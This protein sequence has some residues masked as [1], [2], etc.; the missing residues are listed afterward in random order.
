MKILRLPNRVP[1]P[2]SPSPS[3]DRISRWL[4]R[5]SLGLLALFIAGSASF[6]V[7]PAAPEIAI[8]QPAGITLGNSIL[9][10]GDN[11][12]GQT[13]VPAGLTDVQA[14]AAGLWHTV[15]LK[16]DGTVI[17]WGYN[18]KSSGP[19]AV[20]AGMGDVWAIA[21]GRYHTVALKNDGTVIS[22]GNNSNGQTTLPAG[23]PGA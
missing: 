21:A 22:W 5:S 11:A 23:L 3:T 4:K 15:A 16:N 14:I 18:F 1:P 20:P 9:A 7:A 13:S 8:E 17:A 12:S 6:A 10:W 19:T 2:N